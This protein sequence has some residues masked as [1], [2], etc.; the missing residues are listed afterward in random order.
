MNKPSR[1]FWLRAAW[2]GAAAVAVLAAVGGVAVGSGGTS[3][4]IT[5]TCA[6][7]TADASTLQ[8]DINNSAPGATVMIQGTC[9]LTS[10][11]T[12]LPD[13]TYDGGSASGT[14]LQQDGSMSYVLA[15]AGYVDDY[16][17]TADPMTVRDL[18]VSCNDSGTTD[19]I[20]VLNWLADVEHDYVEDCGGSGIVDT[21]TN[22]AGIAITG[23]SVNSRFDNNMITQSGQNGFEVIDSGNSVTDGYLVDNQIASSGEDAVYLQ[24]SAGW[25]IYGN[26][27][28]GDGEG[29]ISASR[30]YQSTIS[31]NIIEDFGA[32]QT[33]GTWYGITATSQGAVGSVISG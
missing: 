8:G 31:D 2:A 29:G 1:K 21:N 13:R 7:T 10:G 14:V 27:L 16:T 26:H 25:D 23:T 5:V 19:G 24:N 33:S 11:I 28:Y 22:A 15:S 4:V 12:L 20:I 17:T 32:K 30:L 9:L 3:G 6:N 18:T